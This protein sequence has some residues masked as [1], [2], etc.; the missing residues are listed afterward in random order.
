MTVIQEYRRN[1][2]HKE[3]SLRCYSQLPVFFSNAIAAVRS[4]FTCKFI[5]GLTLC[6]PLAAY[7][8][9]Y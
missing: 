9:I 3:K 7:M 1:A 8:R 2:L 6:K 4:G 5:G